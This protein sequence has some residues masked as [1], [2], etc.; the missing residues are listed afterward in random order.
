MLLSPKCCLPLLAA[1]SL[2]PA[3][4]PERPRTFANP[5][6]IEYR[7]MTDLPSRR[8]AA[9]PVIVLFGNE[10]YLFASKSGGYWHST[11]LV[12]WTFVRPTG[13]PIEAYAPAVMVWD[14]A[15][16]Y[17]ACN[18]GLYRSRDP[19]QG[20]WELIG[21]PFDVGD[22]DLF[23]DDDGRV[24]LYY[25][26]SYNG[27]I[28]G[29][30]L[31]PKNQFRRIGEPFVCFRANYA[32]HGWERRGDENLGAMTGST[33][34]EGPWIE[35]AWMTKHGGTY[36]LQYAA[37]GT[38]SRTYADGVY[39]A[40]TPRGP[41]TYAAYS[42]FSHKPT[43][44]ITSAGH[45]ATFADKQGHYWH[46]ATM[47]ISVKHRFERRLGIF[48]AEFD[49]AGQLHVNTL[50]GDYPQLVPSERKDGGVAIQPGWMLLS[51]GKRAKASS[52]RDGLPPENAFDEDIRTYWSARTADA[53]EWLSVDLGKRC[54]ID[55]VQVNFAEHESTALAGTAGL[56]HQY[57]L[58]SSV[59]GKTWETLA[60][61]TGNRKDVPHDY[62]QL[63]A[64]ATAQHVRITNVHM[65]GGG[66]FS[67]RDLRIFGSGGSVRPARAPRFEAHRDAS[68]ARN[69]VV[70][71]EILP[72]A[73]GYIVRYGTAPGKLYHNLEI[74]GQKEI[75]LHDLNTD[76]GY[77]FAVDAF[78]D[79][80]RTLGVPPLAR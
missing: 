28:S 36:Y 3:A 70:R 65:P 44:F 13:L 41:F 14:G 48:P 42:P 45:S 59:D 75:V 62:I 34:Q 69:A 60:D 18:I 79:S 35:G 12:D 24:Y 10:Y 8:E 30:E 33:F 15:L 26:L 5:I 31:D 11:D 61:R 63:P 74:R 1:A 53:G 2:A 67:I 39:T 43:G 29:M 66:P 32:Q 80:G 38:E 78:N 25:G 20:K 19:R 23:A 22:P 40:P 77:S 9:D 37:P 73:E 54:R 17:T 49:N 76:A 58:E 68:D 72:D 27:A 52:S 57:R 47:R 46:V 4:Q 51:Y 7:F 21:K 50:F 6:N 64:P 55:A 16:Y 56:Y 71:W